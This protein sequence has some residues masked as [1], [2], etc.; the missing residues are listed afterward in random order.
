M[1]PFPLHAAFPGLTTSAAGSPRSEG[2]IA[3]IP[4]RRLAVFGTALLLSACGHAVHETGK[5]AGAGNGY[6]AT[7][8]AGPFMVPPGSEIV[9]CTFVQGTNTDDEDVSNF[10]AEQSVGGHHLIVYEVDHPIDLPPTPCIQGGQPAWVQVLGTQDTTEQVTFPSGVGFHVKANQQFVM[11]THYI[12][13]GTSTLTVSSSFSLNYAPVGTVTQQA[14]PY[15]F[16]SLNINIPPGSKWKTDSACSPPAPVNLYLMAGHEHQYGTGVT[17]GLIP[18]SPDGGLGPE[19]PLYATQQWSAPPAQL[20]NPLLSLGTS[21]ELHVTCNW[22]NTGTD[23]LSYPQ[24]MCYAVGIYWP[25]SGALFCALGGNN[26]QTCDCGYEGNF[27]TGPGGSTV[28]VEVTAVSS[29]AGEQGA[30]ISSGHPIYCD[31]FQAQDWPPSNLTPNNGA[32]PWYQADAEGVQLNPGVAAQVTF[33][34]VTPGDYSLFCFMDTI[35]GGFFPGSGDPAN[36]PVVP[37]TAVIG[38]TAQARLQLNF[39]LP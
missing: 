10:F 17:V 30:P 18:G 31:L 1:T 19:Q 8:S 37:V 16:G 4:S 12:N 36:Y 11:E 33:N 23:Q 5:D 21:D 7:Y 24:E 6:D 2:K 3:M 15:F 25:G 38:Q 14:H 9:M 28:Q 26:N 27:D 32:F 13:A 39:A 22:D 34:D 35:S 20:F 29:I